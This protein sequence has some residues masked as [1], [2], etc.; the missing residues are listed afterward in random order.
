MKKS[1][2]RWVALITLLLFIGVPLLVYF[3][4]GD[5]RQVERDCKERC[6]PRFF[7]VGPDP[8]YLVPANGKVAP[9]KC[10]CY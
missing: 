6:Y 7:R 5:G 4:G 10:E 9:L 1:T 8:A 2:A 3:F